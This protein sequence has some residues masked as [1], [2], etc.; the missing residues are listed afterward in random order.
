MSSS[1]NPQERLLSFSPSLAKEVGLNGAIFL[2]ELQ[3]LVDGQ[4]T[5]GE[6]ENAHWVRKTREEWRNEHFPFWSYDVLR[7]TI[8]KLA[9][10]ELI[11]K[12]TVFNQKQSDSTF[13]YC[14]DYGEL[15]FLENSYSKE[16]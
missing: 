1:R 8:D 2:Q 9:D 10:R 14:I 3:H 11:H 5:T 16:F 13:W 6:S 7:R 4:L 12:T 15:E